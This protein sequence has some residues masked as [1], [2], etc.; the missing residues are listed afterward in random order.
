LSKGNEKYNDSCVKL[1]EFLK[2]L[3]NGET[4][5]KD[6]IEL[7]SEKS[8]EECSNPH[9]I[10]NKYLN[11]LKIFGIKIKKK[12]NKYYLLN[13]PYKIDLDSDD[14]KAIAILKE[15][16]NILPN[17]KM[18]SNFEQFFRELEIRYSENLQNITQSIDSISAQRLSFYFSELSEQIRECERYC[19]E[20]HKLEIIYVNSK[21]NDVQ[22]TCSP[23]ELNY[24]KRKICLSVLVQLGG[25]IT[26][27][28]LENIKSI[29]Q[30]PTLA[31]AQKLSTTIVYKLKN[32]LA[33]NYKLRDWEKSKGLDN[34]NNLIVVNNNEDLDVLLRRLMRYG[35]ECVII[36]PKF[37]KEKM[38]ELINDTLSMYDK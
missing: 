17:G 7:F 13:S 19:Q 23:V 15:G 8:D 24:H 12:N 10:L 33:K 3:S 30:L 20:Q 1:F 11:T 29:E 2:L 34:E 35:N 21:N 27:I 6:V 37:L 5:Y 22:I 28:P 4:C 38:I 36:S 9:V 16:L 32:K 14:L 26:E 31:N 25:N 18:R